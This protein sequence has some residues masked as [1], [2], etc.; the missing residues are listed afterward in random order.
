MQRAEPDRIEYCLLNGDVLER[1][2]YP[3]GHETSPN[4]CLALTQHLLGSYWRTKGGTLHAMHA[5]PKCKP[6]PELV[7]T[8]VD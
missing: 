2:P 6:L 5:V 4:Y 1:Y 8:I 3:V 7:P